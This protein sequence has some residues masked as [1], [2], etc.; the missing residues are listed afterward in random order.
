VLAM[1]AY[2]GAEVLLP[3]LLTLALSGCERSAAHSGHF[4]HEKRNPAAHG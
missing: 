1:K 4:S 2:G 3:A